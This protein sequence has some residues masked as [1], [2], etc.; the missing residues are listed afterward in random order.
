MG[1]RLRVFLSGQQDR[2]LFNLRTADVPQKVKDRAEVIRLNT[3]GWYVEKI[4]AYFDWTA[5][6]VRET[7]HRWQKLGMEGLW[8]SEGRGAKPK[9]QEEDTIYLEQCL[10]QEPRTY[11]S[12]QLLDYAPVPSL[13]KRYLSSEGFSR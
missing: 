6:T 1:A 7:I 11:N 9:W 13:Q 2:T 10:K 3:Q 4:A 5:Q 12:R 8:E